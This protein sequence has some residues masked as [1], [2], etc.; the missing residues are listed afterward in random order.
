MPAKGPPARARRRRLVSSLAPA[1]FRHEQFAS[2]RAFGAGGRERAER[3]EPTWRL[4]PH[5]R[6]QSGTR[7]TSEVPRGFWLEGLCIA[8]PGIPSSGIA[9]D[10][11]TLIL[12]FDGAVG[13]PYSSQSLPTP[14]CQCSLARCGKSCVRRCLLPRSTLKMWGRASVNNTVRLWELAFLAPWIDNVAH[15]LAQFC[16]KQTTRTH[17]RRTDAQR[18]SETTRQPAS[19]A[20]TDAVA[21]I[22]RRSETWMQTEASTDREGSN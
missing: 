6:A 16:P 20:Q 3:P 14:R 19:G 10:A 1:L 8:G 15:A 11:S 12:D 5:K 13:G 21:W 2:A 7:I 18:E 4:R 22:P 9:H 17:Q